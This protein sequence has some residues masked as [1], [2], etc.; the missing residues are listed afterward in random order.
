MS[1]QS[2]KSIVEFRPI[3][4]WDG[5]CVSS[6]GF[7]WSAWERTSHKG[8]SSWQI[9]DS[10]RKLKS[11]P[12]N[13]Y[14]HRQVGLHNNGSS[15][16]F[17]VHRLVLEAFVGTCPPGLECRHLDGNPSNNSINNICWD[18]HA[19][20]MAD[21]CK[22]GTSARGERL[23]TAKLTEAQVVEIRRRHHE[24]EVT[25]AQLA[26]DFSIGYSTIQKIVHRYTWRHV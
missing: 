2:S 18:T 15:K 25:M 21:K 16:I 13:K 10:W 20:N 7:V 9:G 6:D 12:Y 1:S 5:Y 19:V 17:T 23:H 24:E 14:G 11:I 4:G 8:T 26:R 3:P 22:H